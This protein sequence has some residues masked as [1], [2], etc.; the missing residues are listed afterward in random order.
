MKD[1]P[2][3]TR[4]LHIVDLA[5]EYK[6]QGIIF[7]YPVHDDAEQLDYP[8][9]KAALDENNIPSLQLELDFTNPIERFRT[10]VEAFLETIEA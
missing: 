2:H 4:H 8:A 7:M 10:R 1:V 5:R 3:R 9:N 6:A